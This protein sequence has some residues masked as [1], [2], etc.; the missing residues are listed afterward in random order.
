MDFGYIEVFGIAADCFQ[1][2][3]IVVVIFLLVRYRKKT[4]APNWSD[5]A[6]SESNPFRHEFLLQ[7]LKHQSEQA[8][9]HIE[10]TIQAERNNVMQ[11]LEL[12]DQQPTQSVAGFPDQEPEEAPFNIE[13]PHNTSEQDHSDDQYQKISQLAAEGMNSRRIAKKLAI[14]LGEV[15]LVM[16]MAAASNPNRFGEAYAAGDQ[17]RRAAR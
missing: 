16:K 4:Q 10:K 7:S 11:L 9:I 8:F 14:P 2:L 6:T 1:V 3:M 17:R 12:S 15:E 13:E 5:W